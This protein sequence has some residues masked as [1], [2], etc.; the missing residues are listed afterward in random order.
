MIR[1]NFTPTLVPVT[2]RPINPIPSRPFSDMGRVASICATMNPLRQPY[3]HPR[4]LLAAAASLILL[5]GDTHADE[6]ILPL[7]GDGFT[8]AQTYYRTSGHGDD[9]DALTPCPHDISAIRWDAAAETWTST[10]P[11]PSTHPNP[12]SN[13][14]MWNQAVYA[15]FDGEIVS[16]WRSMPDDDADG[17]DI[18]CP[19][20]N[21]DEA[22]G[23]GCARRGNH[24][25][26]HTNDGRLVTLAHLQEDTVPTTLCPI[27][28][29]F[30]YTD[31]PVTCGFYDDA[32]IDP[33]IPV[34]KGDF[35]GRVGTSGAG[36]GA[37]L[38]VGLG[39]SR[40]GGSD[41]L[42]TADSLPLDFV[43]T[44]YQ[45][46]ENAATVATDWIRLEGEQLPIDGATDFLLWPDPMGPRTDAIQIEPGD[47]PALAMTKVGGVVAYRNA[48]GNLSSVGF[49]FDG[50]E[51][52]ELG[53]IEEEGGVDDVAVAKIGTS[54]RHVV[55][56]V[57]NGGG[58]LQL[59]PYYVTSD[60]DLIRG[61]GL[62][63]SVASQIAV[64]RSPTHQGVVTAV[65][66]GAGTLTVA[67]FSTQRVGTDITVS[68]NGSATSN[69]PM[70]R[71]AI[72]RI[73]AGRALNETSRAFKGV[74]TAERRND[75][76]LALRTWSVSDTGVVTLEDTALATWAGNTLLVDE[77]DVSVV[78]NNSRE[79]VV[80]SV[81]ERSSDTLRV[82]SFE[83]SSTGQLDYIEGRSAGVIGP[84]ASSP[85]GNGDLL[86]GVQ[87][88]TGT[89]VAASFT[90]RPNF[91]GSG[92][93]ALRRT[94]NRQAG[95]INGIDIGVRGN[96]KDAVIA[97]EDSN[98]EIKLLHYLTNYAV[99]E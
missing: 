30:L 38:H 7:R 78:G 40:I 87:S 93:G 84:V 64:T 63:G 43:E 94:G 25:V 97:V 79:F 99:S 8:A 11:I 39:N 5:L 44:W 68:V 52:F 31:D 29:Q 95:T 17:D 75:N 6:L 59:I 15:P 55:V 72:D 49:G 69:A 14:L 80:A 76:R 18:R 91:A 85:A 4:C 35:V 46:R 32:R 26:I 56:A 21:E 77:V 86:V 48:E 83:V 23:H 66:N 9:C 33:P 19:G 22:A 58:N 16:C 37:H 70:Q 12:L 90:V 74:V 73:V 2:D 34:S 24:V 3:L 28:D 10:P 47:S 61:T 20:G 62:T 57:E 41:Q 89:T 13:H 27:T 88:S 92:G 36:V 71:V 51:N 45:P 1:H 81:R 54:S 96:R 82:L 53:M 98:G 65:R 60:N 42:C 67:D 50:S